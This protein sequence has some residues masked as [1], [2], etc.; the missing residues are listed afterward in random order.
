M[1]VTLKKIYILGI[2]KVP[3]T[4]RLWDQSTNNW[5]QLWKSQMGRS[6]FRTEALTL[7]LSFKP[8]WRTSHTC[9]QSS[10]PAAS[11]LSQKAPPTTSWWRPAASVS[12][13]RCA[14]KDRGSEL[15]WQT[16]TGWRQHCADTYSSYLLSRRTFTWGR[17]STQQ[18][19]DRQEASDWR[20]QRNIHKVSDSHMICYQLLFTRRL[21]RK[22]ALKRPVA[23][24]II[25]YLT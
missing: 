21:E 1:D 17:R 6:L 24:I 10:C 9:A 4:S 15:R 13:P 22:Y 18:P 7:A 20:L 2:K 12:P 3:K 8:A 16:Q 23:S 11:S 5:Y 14:W 19:R 25:F